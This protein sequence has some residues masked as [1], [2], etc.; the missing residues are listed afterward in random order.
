M[1]EVYTYLVNDYLPV[2][3]PTV[4]TK[5]DKMILNRVT[6]ASISLQ[7][8]S[9]PLEA[10]KLLGMNVEDDMFLLQQEPEG[11]RCIAAMCTSP[12]GFDPSEKLGKL[13]KDIHAPVPEYDKIGASM[14]RFFSR[15]E[16]GKNAVR[17]NVSSR[18]GGIMTWCV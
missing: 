15:V 2:R 8:P 16:V 7:A 6:G 17:N 9:D 1:Q 14:E 3:Y 18:H 12:S 4:F 10:F 13:L 11:H 5:T